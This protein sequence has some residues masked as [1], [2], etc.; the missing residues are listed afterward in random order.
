MAREEK[1]Y[2]LDINLDLNK[3]RRE[4]ERRGTF[5]IKIDAGL[6]EGHEIN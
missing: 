6:K 3:G 4:H 1:G 5:G 2:S